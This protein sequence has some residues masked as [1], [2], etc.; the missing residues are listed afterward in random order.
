MYIIFNSSCYFSNILSIYLTEIRYITELHVQRN[1]HLASLVI[2]TENENKLTKSAIATI[3]EI[4]H[5]PINSKD[6]IK[7]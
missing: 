3:R 2:H 6:E 7:L 1:D 5:S 4:I